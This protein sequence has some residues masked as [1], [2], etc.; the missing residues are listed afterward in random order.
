MALV[1]IVDDL[2]DYA[3][4]LSLSLS[5][6]GHTVFVAHTADEAIE[7]AALRPPD[8]LLS[9]WMLS[10]HIHGLDVIRAV[11]VMNPEVR[12]ILMTG[13]ASEDLR[14][15]ALSAEIFD[16]LEKPM[17]LGQILEAIGR[18][19]ES[20]EH[21]HFI[22]PV[23]YMRVL[24]DGTI[25]YATSVA[26]ELCAPPVGP[27]SLSTVFNFEEADLLAS[28]TQAWTT[29]GLRY[30]S[31]KQALVRCAPNTDGS[32]RMIVIDAELSSL[33]ND[34]AVG[35]ILKVN[36]NSATPS[37]SSI[38]HILIVDDFESVRRVTSDV[39]REANCICHS[40]RTEEEAIRIFSHDGEITVVILDFEIPNATPQNVVNTLKTIRPEVKIIGTSGGN[41]AAEFEHLGVDYFLAKP[42]DLRQFFEVLRAGTSLQHN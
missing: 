34:P 7:H 18:A 19:A 5:R 24:S 13:Y 29:V 30:K 23:G 11:Q 9:D 37:L 6:N 31:Q 15:E 40:A 35:R 17:Q 38:G 4:E 39:L 8:V 27:C 21:E 2:Q 25:A 10:D 42:W 28:A 20:H 12:P 26:Q 41:Y 14:K 32:A 36:E 16:F 3:E 22:L 33:I 1:L